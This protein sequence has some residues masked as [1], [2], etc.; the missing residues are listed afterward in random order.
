MHDQRRVSVLFVDLVA[1]TRFAQAMT[2][3][4]YFELMGGVLTTLAG[5]VEAQAG[6]VL[7]FQGDAVLAAFGAPTA[8]VGDPARALQ[9]A[10]TSLEAIGHLGA[11]LGLELH[12]R[13]GVD[14]DLATTGWVGGEYTL[15]GT[16]V[17]RARRLCSAAAVGEVLVSAATWLETRNRAE[18]DIPAGREVRDYPHEA[19]PYRLRGWQPVLLQARP[20]GVEPDR[21]VA[22]VLA[23]N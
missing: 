5:E 13:A 3:D 6:R 11:S 1:S 16:V 8:A 14:T 22:E 4:Q 17:N 18:Y 2:S 20:V 10:Q 12:A 19:G 23:L 15:F 9:A 21:Q 7:Q